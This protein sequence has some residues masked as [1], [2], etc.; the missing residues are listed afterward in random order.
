MIRGEKGEKSIGLTDC[1]YNF[2]QPEQQKKLE[3]KTIGLTDCGYDV[4]QPKEPKKS[5]GDK[6][7][8]AC[9]SVQ[10]DRMKSSVQGR[11]RDKTK[12]KERKKRGRRV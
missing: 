9:A 10:N 5:E 2:I 7:Q 1:G 11:N 3:N 4:I 12:R 8:K 6:P